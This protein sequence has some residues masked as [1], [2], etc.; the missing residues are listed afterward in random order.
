M[1]QFT[2]QFLNDLRARL[3][4][5]AV[6]GRRFKLKKE[7]QEFRAVEDNSLTVNDKKQRWFDNSGGENG[8]IFA[9]TTKFEGCSFPEAVERCAALAGVSL[10]NGTNGHSPAPGNHRVAERNP[11]A[12]VAADARPAGEGA[13]RDAGPG[14]GD[15]E[16]KREIEATYDYPGA[17]GVLVMQVVRYVFRL[18]DGSYE[19]TK[20][21]K[22]K[23]LHLQRRP[24]GQGGW[25]W[26]M[27]GVRLVPYRLPEL[28]EAIADDRTVYLAEGEKCCDALAKLGL[29]ATTNPAGAG[30]WPAH[31]SEFFAGARVVIMPDNDEP[32]RKHADQVAANIADVAASVLVLELPDLPPKGDVVDWLAEGGTAAELAELAGIA[33]V[34]EAPAPEAFHSKFGAVTWG[35]PRGAMEPYNYLIKGIIPRGEAVL[36]YGASQSGKSFFTFDLAMSV[37]RGVPFAGRRTKAG[38]VVYCA[39]EAGVGFITLRMPAYEQHHGVGPGQ[40]PFV[41]L[42]RKFDLFGNEP[43]L[44]DLIAEIKAHAARFDLPLEAVVIDTLN[45]TTPGMDEISGKDVGLVMSR[46]ERIREECKTGLWLVHH[47][48]AAGTGPRGHTSLYAA[49]ETAIEVSRAMSEKDTEERPIRFARLAKQREG[50]D[51]IVWRFVLPQVVIGKDAEGDP[52]ASCVVAPPGGQ[53]TI[54][55][56]PERGAPGGVRPPS[57][58]QSNILRAL[59]KALSERGEPAPGALQLPRSI[60]TVTRVGHWYDAYR[61]TAAEQT[62]DA[63]KQAM[64]RASDHWLER[65]VIGRN[66]PFV[67]ITGRPVQGVI[68]GAE[69]QPSLPLPEQRDP[70]V[71]EMFDPFGDSR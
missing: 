36:I 58:Q 3:P 49:F 40:L 33:L 45:K 51:G 39:A 64:K 70:P 1:A 32:G 53:A 12:A 21:G 59:L 57:P 41:C 65:R 46:L 5:S 16:A 25:I 34:W 60:T 11:P 38:L 18:P 67:W 52:I 69:D 19:K 56:R 15:A 43:Q 42:P 50:E 55:A 10:P 20:D 7:G 2:E 30:K 54:A 35:E 63:V 47:K 4:V 9:F 62:D 29:P 48:N 26:K 66:N 17:D 71:D 31:F 37:A 28:I 6:V 44:V 14:R 24:D 13:E 68:K 22:R 8:D 61:E 23:K 27:E